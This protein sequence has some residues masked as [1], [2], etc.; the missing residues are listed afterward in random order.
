MSDRAHAPTRPAP[1]RRGRRAA[2]DGGFSLIETLVSLA[3]IGTV[4]AGT[5]PFLIRSVTLVSQQRTQQVAVQVANNALERAR[6]ISPAALL[7]GRGLTAVTNQ[8]NGAPAAVRDALGLTTAV[9]LNLISSDTGVTDLLAGATAALPT[10]PQ[11]VT[12]G[13]IAY[14]QNWYVGRCGLP[15][16]TIGQALPGLS[17]SGFGCVAGLANLATTVQYLRVTVA[18][19]WTHK[20]CTTNPASPASRPANECVYVASTLVSAGT[21][22]I[23]DLKRPP[24]TIVNPG[25]QYGYVGDTVNFQLVAAGGTLPRNWTLTGLPP[26]LT[27]AGN[28]S[29]T[30]KTTTAGSYVVA[31]EV[32][33]KDANSDDTTFTWIVADLPVLTSPG[34]QVFRTTT[35]VS[36]APVLTGGHQPLVWTATGLPLGLV[37]DATTGVVS[38]TPL[39][40]QSTPQTATVSVVDR[41]RKTA[42]TSFTWRTFT[43]VKMINPGSFSA[44]RGDNG[45]YN[46][47]PLA[48]GGLGPYTWSANSLP[49]GMTINPSTGA[50]SGIISAGTR[51]LSTV[52]VTD[53]AGGSASVTALVTVAARTPS[54]VRVTAPNPA[55]PDQ[56]T[57]AGSAVSLTAAAAG[58]SGYTWTATGLPAGLSISPGGL[59]S[60]RPT[61]PGTSTVTLTVTDT[62]KNVANLM[63]VWKVNP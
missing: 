6:A 34:P 9:P 59:I 16:V 8:L 23:F 12:V 53:S 58:T 4:M 29:I 44:T 56:S 13:G 55:S 25:T 38:G 40:T 24:P 5:A 3:V 21:D 35:P 46:L 48:S 57:T 52:T 18:V 27:V 31:A 20:D 39:T 51:Y 54:D 45:V 19:T 32:R 37:I 36:L 63:F 41:G 33:D 14:Q 61:A 11:E 62:A 50:T 1:G 47:G 22:P 17:D 43:P 10:V 49:P 26:G 28:G 30:G 7:S 60:G 2:G 15:K 42:S